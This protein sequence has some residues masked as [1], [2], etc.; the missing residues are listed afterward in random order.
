MSPTSGNVP[1]PVVRVCDLDVGALFGKRKAFFFGRRE[2]D[3]FNPSEIE[4]I[5]TASRLFPEA[6][7]NLPQQSTTAT[8]TISTAIPDQT[9]KLAIAVALLRS[10][11]SSN[12][13]PPAASSSSSSHSE[14]VSQAQRW[15]RKAKDR[16]QEILRLNEYLKELENASVGDLYPQTAA[17]KCYFF[18]DLGKFSPNQLPEHSAY[19]HRLNDTLR[20][21]FLRQVR[22]REKRKRRASDSVIPSLFTESNYEDSIDLLRLSADFLLDLCSTSSAIEGGNFANWTHQAVDFILGSLKN[23]LSLGKDTELIQITINNLVMHLITRMSTPLDEDV[24][25]NGSDRQQDVQHI[26]RKLGSMSY[27]GQRVIVFVSQKIPEFTENLLCLDPFEASFASMHDSMFLLIQ[28]IDF[29]IS[30][31][32]RTWPDDESF[33]NGLFE[34]WVALFCRSHKALELHEDRMGLYVLYLDRVN[35]VLLRELGQA[36]SLQKLNPE[37]L[38]SLFS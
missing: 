18:S 1:L 8:T 22:L 5:N 35:S 25:N 27:V 7:A 24:Q 31:Y 29:M 19:R 38:Q 26:I 3:S 6:M 20:R 21:R 30:D 28:L 4:S 12:R 14:I 16:K 15:K 33:D 10:K 17:C 36:S 11:L 37:I 9:I 32:L 2:E 13:I 23:L 34:E